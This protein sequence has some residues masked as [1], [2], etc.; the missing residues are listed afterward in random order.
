M[1]NSSLNKVIGGILLVAGTCIGA[2]MLGLPIATGP[3]GFKAALSAF[4]LCWAVMLASA[5]LMLE[6]SLWFPR[7]VNLIAMARATLGKKGAAVAWGCFL[8]FLYAL[9]AAYTAGASGIVGDLLKKQGIP[10]VTAIVIVIGLFAFIV[11]LGTHWVDG[12]NRFLMVSLAFFYAFLVGALVPH[13][14]EADWAEGHASYLWSTGPLLVTAFGFHLLIP[15]LKQYLREDLTALRYALW[16]G[17]GLALLVYLLWEGIVLGVVPVF[18]EQG[19]VAMMREEQLGGRQS[20]VALTDFLSAET[21]NPQVALY[22]TGFALSAILTSFIGVALALSDFLADGLAI[23]KTKKGKCLLTLLT[24]L[25][26]L[27]ITLCYPQFLMILQ[28]AG[29]FAVILLIVYPAIMAWEGRYRLQWKGYRVPGGKVLI[30][31]VLLGGLS[32]IGLDVLGKIGYL[33]KPTSL[34][35]R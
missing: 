30:I 32:V 8:L 34:I 10:P 4:G 16:I 20:V 22:A 9:L 27:A 14:K 7:E 24:F 17:S 25:P 31:G 6:V 23:P 13:F 35:R 3:G 18:G 11:A 28:F 5:F 1:A 33:P 15:T 29:I 26:P 19:L 2:G 21:R 12:L